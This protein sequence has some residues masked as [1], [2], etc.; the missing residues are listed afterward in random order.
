MTSNKDMVDALVRIKAE[1]DLL[2]IKEREMTNEREL[3]KKKISEILARE[4]EKR[5]M[6]K[7]KVFE[8]TCSVCKIYEITFLEQDISLAKSKSDLQL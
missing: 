8:T 1:R 2:R 3:V 7:Q 6:L 4:S 5:K